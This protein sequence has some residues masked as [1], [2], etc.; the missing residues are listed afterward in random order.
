VS[1]K[2]VAA[3]DAEIDFVVV[4][5]TL[6][7]YKW[8]L[9]TLV[10]ISGGLGAYLAFTTPPIYRAEVTVTTVHE[11]GIGDGG[12]SLASQLGGLAS[13]AGLGLPAGDD[14]S[15]DAQAVLYSRHLVEEFITRNHLQQ[16]F[17]R[18][19]HGPLS[20][21]RVVLQF[22]DNVLVIRDDTRKGTTT[23]DIDWIDPAVA[24]QWANGFV[25]LA[26]ELIRV[27]ALNDSSRNIA[28]LNEQIAKTHV[29]EIQQV[30]YNLIESETKALMLANGRAEYAFAVVDPAVAPEVRISPKRT[31]MILIGIVLGLVIGSVIALMHDKRQRLAHLRP[32]L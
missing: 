23:I 20:L 16:E 6:L 32:A 12:S 25:A 8:L 28:Y 26:N 1:P 2:P 19:A 5:H 15:R 11:R 21:W 10:V 22:R 29:V 17:E 7:G 3:A 14:S 4:M 24:A 13:I 30:M 9:G 31:V 27:R 18:R